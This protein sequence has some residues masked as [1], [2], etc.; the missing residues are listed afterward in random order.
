MKTKVVLKFVFTRYDNKVKR[1]EEIARLS[2]ESDPNK[3]DK[4]QIARE[5][6]VCNRKLGEGAFGTVYGG[7]ALFYD[8][9]EAVAVKALRPGASMEV[10]VTLIL[11]LKFF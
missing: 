10:K 1:Y 4:F 11:L 5:N 6:V 2:Q 9:W 7:E 8:V 3:L